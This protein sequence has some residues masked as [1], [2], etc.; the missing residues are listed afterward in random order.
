MD[1]KCDMMIIHVKMCFFV[2]VFSSGRGDAPYLGHLP[3]HSGRS[4]G[5]RRGRLVPGLSLDATQ[6]SKLVLPPV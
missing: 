3:D 5:V 2:F 4:A 6:D 1:I